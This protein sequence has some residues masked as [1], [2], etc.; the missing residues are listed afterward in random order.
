V[1]AKKTLKVYVNVCHSDHHTYCPIRLLLRLHKTEAV[2]LSQQ[3]RTEQT[4]M[5][6][7]KVGGK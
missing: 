4:Q 2:A 1:V 3:I 5:K 7:G 6:K